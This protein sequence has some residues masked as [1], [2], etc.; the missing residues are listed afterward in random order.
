MSD[1]GHYD[2]ADQAAVDNA[3]KE[4][5]R[6]DKEDSETLRVWMSHPKGRD[7]LYRF[8]FGVCHLGE[9]FVATDEHGRSDTH[10]TYLHLGE[11]NIG[12]WL[13]NRL[14][15]HPGLYQSMLSEQQ[16]EAEA[17]NARLMKQNERKEARD[18]NG[19]DASEG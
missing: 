17:R 7:L 12:A 19:D 14:R 6:R 4:A 8:V 5:S 2:A 9:T 16:L 1:Q 15:S 10:R 3:A 13:D 18:G 11:R